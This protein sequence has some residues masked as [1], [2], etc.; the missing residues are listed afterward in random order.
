MRSP[1][2]K[3]PMATFMRRLR[4][5]AWSALVGVLAGTLLSSAPIGAQ[6]AASSERLVTQS[7]DERNLVTL[8]GTLRPELSAATDRGAV[9]DSL[10]LSHMYLQL[11]RSAA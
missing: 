10:L 6:A 2:M 4:T 5:G 3:V 1:A 8:A 9:S 7:V 11:N